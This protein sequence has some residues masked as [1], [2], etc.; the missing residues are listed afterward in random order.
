[1]A[2][3]S[4]ASWQC[5]WMRCAKVV[6][7]RSSQRKHSRLFPS[8]IVAKWPIALYVHLAI[9]ECEKIKFPSGTLRWFHR[10]SGQSEWTVN[11]PRAVCTWL[12]E[13]PLIRLMNAHAALL[14]IAPRSAR[15][16]CTQKATQALAYFHGNK[17]N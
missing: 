13:L 16:T 6:E 9:L 17:P 7:K 8:S 12:K 3:E 15:I 11:Y 14:S 1:M 4:G 2:L 10:S 5:F